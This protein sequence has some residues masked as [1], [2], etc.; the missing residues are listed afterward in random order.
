MAR[1]VSGV[2]V[3]MPDQFNL[4]VDFATPKTYT[5]IRKGSWDSPVRKVRVRVDHDAT[6]TGTSG[7]GDTVVRIC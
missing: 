7:I 5:A 6:G 1:T 4:E 3:I 2:E